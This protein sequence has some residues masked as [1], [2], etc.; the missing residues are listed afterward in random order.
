MWY[1]LS[2]SRVPAALL[3]T[4]VTASKDI[5]PTEEDRPQNK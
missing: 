2:V 1:V 4:E 3:G 5:Q